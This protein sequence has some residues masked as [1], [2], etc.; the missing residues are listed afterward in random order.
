MRQMEVMPRPAFE[1]VAKDCACQLKFPFP[2]EEVVLLRSGVLQH[3]RKYMQVR[4]YY[5]SELHAP[6]VSELKIVSRWAPWKSGITPQG[7]EAAKT[8]SQ[9]DAGRPII[10]IQEEHI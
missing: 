6:F 1:K 7:V 3:L 4:F 9:S 10:R 5:N 2:D 8:V